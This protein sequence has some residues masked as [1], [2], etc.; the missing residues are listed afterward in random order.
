M[1]SVQYFIHR[2]ERGT[3]CQCYGLTCTYFLNKAADLWI[4]EWTTFQWNIMILDLTIGWFGQ[5]CSPTEAKVLNIRNRDQ[6]YCINTKFKW[7]I[8]YKN[9]PSSSIDVIVICW[10][11]TK[12][13]LPRGVIIKWKDWNVSDELKNSGIRTWSTFLHWEFMFEILQISQ[14]ERND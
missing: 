1:P 5:V 3:H 10:C 8:Y 11:H 2:E 14:H 13:T 9:V 4:N 7:N 6:S 12:T